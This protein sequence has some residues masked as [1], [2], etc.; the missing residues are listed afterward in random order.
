M[1][2]N[3]DH[4]FKPGQSGNPAGRPKK[5]LN[6]KTV[7]W[8]NLGAF[9]IDQNGADRVAAEMAEVQKD[10]QTYQEL[11]DSQKDYTSDKYELYNQRLNE[12]RDRFFDM[13]I[14]LLEYFKPKMARVHHEGGVSQSVILNIIA[15]SEEKLKAIH[16]IG[17]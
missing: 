16:A 17:E 11:R 13:Y 4:L 14:R 3:N 12:S 10:I 15:E 5:S 1:S 6:K 2:T 8:N 7:A 9:L